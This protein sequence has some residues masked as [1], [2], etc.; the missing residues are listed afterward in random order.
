[1]AA[2]QKAKL[3]L[4]ATRA[5]VRHWQVVALRPNLLPSDADFCRQ[6]ERSARAEVKLRQRHLDWLKSQPVK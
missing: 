6:M 3:E 5:E 1:M 4:E 2:L